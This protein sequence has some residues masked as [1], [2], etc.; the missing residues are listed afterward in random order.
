MEPHWKGTSA[1]YVSSNRHM[2]R[3]CALAALAL[4]LATACQPDMAIPS[5]SPEPSH[6][7]ASPTIPTKTPGGNVRDRNRPPPVTVVGDMTVE[8]SAW[9]YCY[10]NRC[11]AGA[12]PPNPPDVGEPDE[13]E[14]SFPL[15]GWRFDAIFTPADEKCG[16]MQHIRLQPTDEGSF[17]LGPAGF[18]GI[19]D[20]T[21]F[22]RGEGDL[23]VTFRWTTPV[24]GPLPEP[25]ARLAILADED[26]KETSYGVEL[27]ISNLES[28][29]DKA[30]AR[31]TVRSS[32]GRALS[33]EAAL[34][35]RRCRPEG[36]LY[37][38][39]PDDKGLEAAALGSRPFVYKV[40]LKLDG[41]R[42]VA[43]ATWP[44]DQIPGNHPSVRLHFSP[45]LPALSS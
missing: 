3:S 45:P 39:R 21:L 35:Q 11:I 7:V 20:V 10:G 43:R 42:Y 31:I 4:L 14:I 22:G 12:P 6:T 29:P 32:E 18:A 15:S 36:S 28:T 37:F 23:S 26:G 38:D 1:S 34:A 2:K 40:E 13:V 25:Q 16:R 30:K 8:L 5:A 33:F 19:Y 44:K 9:S 24:D 41:K 27:N 17:V